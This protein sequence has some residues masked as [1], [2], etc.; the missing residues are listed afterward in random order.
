VC[1]LDI[2]LPVM[3]G[4]ELARRLRE[5]E[6]LPDDLRIIAVTGYGQDADRRRSKEAGF[7]AHLVKPVNLD[8]LTNAV[9]H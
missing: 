7:N 4:Y 8:T 6:Q 9:S 5:F 1:L 2:G 3:D